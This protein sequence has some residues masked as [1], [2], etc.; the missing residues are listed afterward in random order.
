[1]LFGKLKSKPVA[2]AS[3]LVVC[4]FLILAVAAP[5][6]A[7]FDPIA[8]SW[9]VIRKA[10]NSIHWFGTDEIGRDI[11]SRIIWGARASLSAGFISVLISLAI[12]FPLGLIAGFV[13][14]VL[15][16]V[17]SRVT[18]ALLACPFLI[19]AIALASF[20]GPSLMNA[21]ISIGISASPIFIRLT[22]GQVI[23]VMAQDYIEAAVAIG[24]TPLK[25][26]ISHVVPN[27]TTPIIVQASLTIA[28]AVIAEASLSFLGLGQQPPSPSWGSML[29][30]AK[31]YLETAPWMAVFPG[32]CIF[33]LVVCFNL[34]GDGLREILDPKLN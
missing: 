29:N 7:P 33:L 18:D 1:M 22:R 26:A 17:I 23:D 31:D 19:L 3:T 34:M 14:G 25:I 32:A 6:I 24:S 15:D 11:L 5:L 4:L 9:S 12:G 30:T 10:P 2:F 27:I 13:G 21:M 28:A 16:T 20:M 8:S